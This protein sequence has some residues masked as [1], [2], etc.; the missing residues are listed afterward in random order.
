MQK[1]L[2]PIRHG[3]RL[4]VRV[5]KERVKAKVKPSPREVKE[6]T[7]RKGKRKVRAQEA[8]RRDSLGNRVR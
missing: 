3:V 6:L 2:R 1:P 4:V 8:S 5:A 7:D